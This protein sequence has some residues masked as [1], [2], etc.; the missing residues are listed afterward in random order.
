MDVFYF[1]GIFIFWLTVALLSLLGIV[2]IVTVFKTIIQDGK[3]D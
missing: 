1:I 3:E 2:L